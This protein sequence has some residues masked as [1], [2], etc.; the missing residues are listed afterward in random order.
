MEFWDTHCHLTLPPLS[1]DVEGALR[2]RIFRQECA[3]RGL[4]IA[5][6]PDLSGF[7]E[8]ARHAAHEQLVDL[9]TR[10]RQALEVGERGIPG[11]RAG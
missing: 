1:G 6:R 10:R 8:R 4:A 5:R 3:E 9:E 11:Q 2:G 7:A